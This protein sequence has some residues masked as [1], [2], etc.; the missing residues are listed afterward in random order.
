MK[1]ESEK[2]LLKA[3]SSELEQSSI[4]LLALSSK[5]NIGFDGKRATNNLTGLGNYSR[6]L[7]KLLAEK[8]PENRYLVYTPKVKSNLRIAS[9]VETKGLEVKTPKTSNFL[10]RS[11]GILKDLIN[12]GV[13]LYHGLSQEIPFAINHSKIKSV[14]TIHDLI[15]LRFPKYYKFLDRKIYTFKSKYACKNANSIIAISEKTKADIVELYGIPEDKIKVIYQTC[16]DIFKTAS[17]E[18]ELELVSAKYKLPSSYLLNVGTIEERKNLLSLIRA[19]PQ[20]SQA[21]KLV[22]IGKETSYK[23]LVLEEIKKLKLQKQVIFLK[24]VPFND[25]PAIYQLSKAFI[26]PSK[27]EGF[28]IP[29]LEALYSKTPV[30]AATGSCLEEAGGPTSLYVHPDDDL[31]LAK[32]IETVLHST[33]LRNAMIEKGL[34]H[35]SK[36]NSEKI[37][38]DVM[39][40]YLAVMQ[41]N[42]N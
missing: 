30:I 10:W 8:R 41:E 1:A 18:E 3:E 5:L 35:A 21:N 17:T 33:A 34:L 39:N 37:T 15:F 22:V 4:G 9:F 24:N 40:T 6:S 11:F 20:L 29:I 31:A 42:L 28:G 16:D 25:L 38:A 14:V 27:Y 7:I 23:K 13:D 36:F 19:L 12:D 2:Q 32:A 26:Y